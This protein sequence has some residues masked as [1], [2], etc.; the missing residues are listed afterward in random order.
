MKNILLCLV[1][2]TI[3][4]SLNA[5]NTLSVDEKA[6]AL[7][8]SNFEKSNSPFVEK[9][10]IDLTENLFILSENMTVE[11]W[12]AII[13]TYIRYTTKKKYDGVI[14][15][16]GTDTLA[17]SAALF[18]MLLCKTDIPVF[19]VS[20]H[21]RLDAADANGNENFKCAVEWIARGI[22]PNVYVTYKNP[23]DG[24]MY[25]HIASRLEQCKNYSDDFYSRDMLDITDI[26]EENRERYLERIALLYPPQKKKAF[27]DIYNCPK[28]KES[29][30]LLQPYVG[31]NYDA[32][33]FARFKAVLHLTFHS[34]TACAEKNGPNSILHM[35]KRCEETE[36]PIDLYLSPAKLSGE[37]YET[38]REI[39]RK[40]IKFL[41]GYTA[42]IAY[43]KL[44]IAY[45]C[46]EN[47]KERIDFI[48]TECNFEN[49]EK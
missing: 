46:F 27:L 32:Y 3:C 20:S 33:D 1:G 17:Y 41:Y 21:K 13:E 49:I 34:G 44:L 23:S 8:K 18:S 16:H 31:I 42:E 10:H 47:E 14:F 6:G 28:L 7:I 12:N 24:R 11:K 5:D 4:T 48:T 36:T 25:L 35:I 45:S 39:G 15:A 30:L 29:V 2:G 26:S 37:I 22:S 19:F 43:A 40:K 38:I 9:V